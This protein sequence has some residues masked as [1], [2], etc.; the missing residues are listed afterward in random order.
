MNQLGQRT[1]VSQAGSAFATAQSIE[2][3]Y[4]PLGQVTE[5]DHSADNS[6]DR[7]FGYDQIGNRITATEG[8]NAAQSYTWD[9]DRCE[10]AS[11]GDRSE[12][13]CPQGQKRRK[14]FFDQNRLLS[15]T[16]ASSSATAQYEYDYLSRRVKKAEGGDTTTYLY[17]GWNPVLQTKNGT[18]HTRYSWGMDLSGSMQGAG[19][20]GG[21]LSV[22]IRNGKGKWVLA[23]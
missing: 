3:G 6:Q 18:E 21:L 15:T 17:E 4:D 5:A 11:I 9:G 16:E 13:T 20:V 1:Q 19:G 12:A 10:Q 14:A 2:W 7:N 22:H 23:G 8:S